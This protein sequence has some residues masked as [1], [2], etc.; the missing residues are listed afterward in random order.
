MEA[1]GRIMV[2]ALLCVACGCVSLGDL[3]GTEIEI[4]GRQQSIEQQV[5]G[6][7]ENLGDEVY[8]LAGVRSVDPMSG[9]PTPPPPATESKEGALRAR[10]RMEFNRDDIISFE[11][12]GYVGETMGGLLKLLDKEM[13]N[14]RA[15]DQRRYD[16]VRAV[17]EEENE[18]RGTVMRRIVT[19]NPDLRGEA[20]MEAVGRILASRYRRDAPEGAKVQLPDGSWTVKAGASLRT[21][22]SNAGS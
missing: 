8:L 19:A 4:T 15:E 18:D 10:R 14:L 3:V 6:S 1:K 9:E 2:V 13:Q 12:A 17:A 5:L 21:G 22:R 20:G 7:F 11:K 16:L